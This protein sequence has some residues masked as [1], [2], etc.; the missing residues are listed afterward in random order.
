[1]AK[2]KLPLKKRFSIKDCREELI[3][4]HGNMVAHATRENPLFWVI[5]GDLLFKLV[6][7]ANKSL[8]D[9]SK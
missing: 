7:L 3:D 4:S 5:E 6:R 1:M 9:G 2:Y 8:K